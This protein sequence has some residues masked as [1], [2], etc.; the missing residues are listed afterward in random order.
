METEL[1]AAG[2]DSPVLTESSNL[3]R[4]AFLFAFEHELQVCKSHGA[5]PGPTLA[6]LLTSVLIQQWVKY[7]FWYRTGWTYSRPQGTS[8]RMQGGQLT[9]LRQ[10]SSNGSSLP[11]ALQVNFLRYMSFSPTYPLPPCSSCPT[12]LK[13]SKPS[14]Q[15]QSPACKAHGSSRKTSSS[16]MG[17]HRMDSATPS[18]QQRT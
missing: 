13:A 12:E 2:L 10:E 7:R 1:A 18:T 15:H 6:E 9:V 16:T 3:D 14:D 5:V 17:W 4:K 11:G 8:A